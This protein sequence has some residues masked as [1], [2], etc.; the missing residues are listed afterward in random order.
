MNYYKIL[1][2]NSLVKSERLKILG[3]GILYL[4]G[5]RYQNVFLDPVLACNFRC[6]MCYFSDPDYKPAGG[7]IEPDKL[8]LLAKNFF[9]NALKLQIGCGAEPGLYKHNADIIRLAKVYSVPH[10]SYTTNASL[11]D[12]NKIRELAEAG[13]DELIVS[14]HGTGKEV[15]EKMMPGAKIEKLYEVLNAVSEVKKVYPALKLRINYTVNP[16][17]ISDLADFET[18]LNN[19][20]IDILQIRPLRRLGNSTYSDFNLKREQEIYSEVVNKL[21]TQCAEKGVVSLITHQIPDE[22]IIRKI[23]DIGDYTYCYVSPKH[24]G[25]EAFDPNLMSYRQFLRKQGFCMRVIKD[26]FFTRSRKIEADVNFG[27]YDVNI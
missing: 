6:V 1:R 17:N 22:K 20:D 3:A 16:D 19:F 4:F 21:E 14:M 7:R 23:P 12:Y 18:Y 13:L 25:D 10:I 24:W 2:L 27:N 15:Y 5:K 8:D 26:V 9:K 11:L